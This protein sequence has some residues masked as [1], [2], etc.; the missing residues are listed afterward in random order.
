[1][2]APERHAPAPP[3]PWFSGPYHVIAATSMSERLRLAPGEVMQ[4]HAGLILTTCPSCGSTV[5]G[6]ATVVPP[7]DAPSLTRPLHCGAKCRA[8]DTWFQIVSGEARYAEPPPPAPN[9]ITEKLAAAGVHAP[10]RLPPDLG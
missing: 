6:T 8:C 2:S 4:H 1:M 3:Q 7:L 5:M 10:P 9:R